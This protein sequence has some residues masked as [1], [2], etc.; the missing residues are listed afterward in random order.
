MVEYFRIKVDFWIVIFLLTGHVGQLRSC[1]AGGQ[2]GESC[3]ELAP[4][5][6]KTNT[7]GSS[8]R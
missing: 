5:P 7:V 3:Q 2:D 4:K 6:A 8:Q 1:Y